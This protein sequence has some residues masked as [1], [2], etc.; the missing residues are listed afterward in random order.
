[1]TSQLVDNF[2]HRLAVERGYSPNTLRAYAGDL[3]LFGEFLG[4]RGLALTEAGVRD[5][6]GFMAT[7][8]VKGLARSTIARDPSSASGK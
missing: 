7:L 4:R 1:M 8:Q 5:V 2:L 6:R 3:A